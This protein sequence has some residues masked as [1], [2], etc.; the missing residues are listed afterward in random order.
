MAS[1]G[2]TMSLS[3]TPSIVVKFIILCV[4]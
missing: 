2:T 3:G 4:T 1:S